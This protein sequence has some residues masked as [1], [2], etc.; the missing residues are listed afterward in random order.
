MSAPI[1][2]GLYKSLVLLSGGV[3]SAMTAL[4]ACKRHSKVLLLTFEYQQKNSRELLCAKRIAKYFGSKVTH[5]TCHL[6]FRHIAQSRRSALLG[7][8]I[9][10]NRQPDFYVPG[11]NI[12]FLS[13]AAAIA[14][15]YNVQEIY[16]GS[17]VQETFPDCAETFLSLFEKALRQGLK[18]N[19]NIK[20]CA[21]FLEMSKFEIIRYGYDNHFDFGLTWSCYCNG[22]LACGR[23]K[24]CYARA[25]NFHWAG[26]VDPVKYSKRFNRVLEAACTQ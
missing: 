1:R 11:R 25:V 9:G 14:E 26:L 13:N 12:I 4:Y 18:F 23:C 21:P 2:K 8:N 16:I 6:D 3:D 5:I 19:K 20:I 15:S 17:H 22:P 24:A 7:D 10:H